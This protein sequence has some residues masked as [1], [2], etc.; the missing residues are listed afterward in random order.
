MKARLGVLLLALL[1]AGVAHADPAALTVCHGYGCKTQ[2]RIAFDDAAFATLAEMLRTADDAQSERYAISAVVARMYVEAGK[3]TPIWRD[4]GGDL[5]D[6]TAQEGA[7]DCIDHATNTT[8]FLKLLEARGMLRFHSVGAPVRRGFV[9]EH[10][11]A[12]LV[13]HNGK[14]YTVDSWFY[15]FG[16]PAIVMSLEDWRAGHRPPGIMAGF[17]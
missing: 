17:R 7:M 11:A 12:T 8:T 3:Q 1:A 4:R 13:E 6:D 10:W 15:D 9:A 2:E 5:N 14:S 16:T